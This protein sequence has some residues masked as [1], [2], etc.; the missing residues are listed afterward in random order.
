MSAEDNKPTVR[1]DGPRLK[2]RSKNLVRKDTNKGFTMPAYL[3]DQDTLNNIAPPQFV[4]S[5]DEKLAEM[6]E[7]EREQFAELLQVVRGEKGWL[8]EDVDDWDV[9][10]FMIARPEKKGVSKA[11]KM[12]NDHVE[13]KLETRPRMVQCKACIEDKN[14]HMQQ[15]VGWDSLHRPVTY[16]SYLWAD[17]KK[18]REAQIAVDHNIELARQCISLMPEGVE[19]WVSVVDFVSY[20]LWS[21]GKAPVAK[22]VM[23][24]M[25]ANYPERLGVQYLVDPPTTFFVAIKALTP[26]LSAK[27]MGKVKMVYTEAEPN[28]RDEFPKVFPPHLSDY[29]IDAFVSNKKTYA[30]Q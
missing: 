25:E 28:I 13:W 12:L 6:T 24:C 15:F 26:F 18:R 8:K 14:T 19:Q 10:R 21:D 7:K 11:V 16:T 3:T 4:R 2:N 5:I 23:G 22:A 9:L 29:L 27:T 1:N 30:E 20:S 17:T